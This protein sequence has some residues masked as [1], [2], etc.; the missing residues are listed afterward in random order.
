MTNA[1]TLAA[2]IAAAL[3][4]GSA[5][6]GDGPLTVTI[7]RAGETTGPSYDPTIGPDQ[8][9]TVNALVSEFSVMERNASMIDATDVKLLVA[10]GQGVVPTSQ[11]R[12]TLNGKTRAIKN[13]MPLQP[14]GADLMYS[15]QVQS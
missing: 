12:V 9:F 4:E 1:S 3:A 2:E 8:T 10:A 13:V 7:I 11:D 15:L 5:A 6:V 14:G